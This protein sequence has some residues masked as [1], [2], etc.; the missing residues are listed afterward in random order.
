MPIRYNGLRGGRLFRRARL[1]EEI[2]YYTQ[3][4]WNENWDKEPRRLF[5]KMN[6]SVN[7][8]SQTQTA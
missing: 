6:R 7:A 4:K 8:S 2:R 3:G 1:F 5:G